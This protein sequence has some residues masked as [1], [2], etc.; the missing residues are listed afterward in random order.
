MSTLPPNGQCRNCKQDLAPAAVACDHCH[1]LVHTV[2]LE[3]LSAKAKAAEAR[4]DHAEAQRAWQASLALLPPASTQ[5]SWIKQHLAANFPQHLATQPPA[6]AA[7]LATQKKHFQWT[8]VLSF[9]AFLAIYAAASGLTFGIGFALLIAI[10][11]MGHFIDIKRRGLPAD[12]PVFLPGL[13]AYVRWD[14]IGVPLATRGAI[15][16]AGPFAGLLGSIACAAIWSATHIPVWAELARVNAMLNILNLI[17]VW[18]LDGG[19][20]AIAL[21]RMERIAVAIASLVLWFIFRENVLLLVAL[22]ACWRAFLSKDFPVRPSPAVT[23][24]FIATLAGLTLLV[25]WLP[26]S[27]FGM[28]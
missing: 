6:D 3:Q 22:G 21:S 11:E 28:R 18:V 7:A 12:M 27:G 26:G 20:A 15:S 17:P 9:A 1:T 24:Y 25:H 19:H 23:A 10:H 5:A 14:A 4:G 13:G 8:T 2:E 16:L